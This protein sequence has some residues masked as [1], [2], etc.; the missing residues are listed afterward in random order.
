[1]SNLYIS[2]YIESQ[3]LKSV[4]REQIISSLLENKWGKEDIDIAFLELDKKLEEAEKKEE[5]LLKNKDNT[6]KPSLESKINYRQKNNFAKV[7]KD[8]SQ[9]IS[10]PLNIIADAFSFYKEKFLTLITVSLITQIILGVIEYCFESSFYKNFLLTWKAD[11]MYI[12][13][14]SYICLALIYLWIGGVIIASIVENNRNEEVGVIES[15][16][17][18]KT[19]LSSLLWLTFLFIFINISIS[20][21]IGSTLI[22][23]T[24]FFSSWANIIYTISVLL[25]VLLFIIS[26]IWYILANLSLFDENKLGIDALIKAREYTYGRWVGV[27]YR[28]IFSAIFPIAIFLIL[29]CI[30]ILIPNDIDTQIK[31]MNLGMIII[32]AVIIFFIPLI[33]VYFFFLYQN[34]K[35]TQNEDSSKSSIKYI[36]YLASTCS[37]GVIIIIGTIIWINT[38]GKMSDNLV[39]SFKKNEGRIIYRIISNYKILSN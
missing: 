35:D 20:A 1:M 38:S 32:R 26:I 39:S 5:L 15:F 29:F 7:K 21:I 12:S 13:I 16:M 27:I 31:E 23:T 30:A 9:T 24:F 3:L 2:D 37:L 4:E 22:V 28:F 36:K 33:G 10:R 6:I 18:G 8:T 17:V 25:E 34:L 11:E 14:A 19:K